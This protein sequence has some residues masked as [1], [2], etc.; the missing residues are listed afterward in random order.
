MEIADTACVRDCGATRCHARF[1]GVNGEWDDVTRNMR[2]DVY[3]PGADQFARGIEN[4][5]GFCI[6]WYIERGDLSINDGNVH[7]L[8]CVLR[9]IKYSST[10]NQQV[11][12]HGYLLKKLDHQMRCF[13]C[14]VWFQRVQHS[15]ESFERL[16]D[17]IVRHGC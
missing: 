11:C 9:W 12:L 14:Y 1:V 16:S 2:M 6:F 3:K 15:T 8:V 13:I 4:F 10:A 7:H 17:L 5:F